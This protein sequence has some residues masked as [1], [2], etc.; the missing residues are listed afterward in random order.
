MGNAGPGNAAWLAGG[1]EM[2]ARMRAKD[3]SASPLG[4][5]ETWPESIK[6][7]VSICLNSRF[8]I[9]L[10]AGPELRVLYN[11]A[12]IPLLGETKH[13]AALG[14]AGW[15]VW[16]D[17]WPAIGPMLDEAGGGRATWV[18]DFQ[19]FYQRRRPREEVYVTFTYSPIFSTHGRT[20]D[21]VF[22]A[23]IETTEK[24]VGA[25]RLLTL[26]NLGKRSPEQRTVAAACREAAQIMQENSIDIPFAAIYLLDEQDERAH[27]IATVRLSDDDVA[28]PEHHAII[29]GEPWPFAQAFEAQT[30]VQVDDL[31]DTGRRFP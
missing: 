26:R 20:V 27:R 12:Y 7:A 10:W 23:C 18:E 19:F 28:F 31:P 17:I 22:C 11:D 6:T 25:R 16:H 1:G 21:G 8:P 29:D 14:E 4:R 5:P 24:V 15:D 9:V 3:W 30:V 2:G 13:P